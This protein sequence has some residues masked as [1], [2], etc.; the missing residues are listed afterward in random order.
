MNWT[1]AK[2]PICTPC[3]EHIESLNLLKDMKTLQE[4]M[5]F[6]D[7]C[8]RNL[9]IAGLLLKKSAK[10]GLS[11]YNIGTLLYRSGYSS[12]PS[13]VEKILENAYDLYKTINKSLSS[14]L[15]IEKYLSDCVKPV[16]RKRPRAL[17]S[18][19]TDFE[20]FLPSTF[21]LNSTECTESD[22]LFESVVT[23]SEVSEEE[24]FDDDYSNALDE[25]PTNQ[26]S[27]FSSSGLPILDDFC[28]DICEDE[29]FNTKLFY[30][31][32]AFMDITIQKKVK[33]LW[34]NFYLESEK[35]GGRIRSCSYALD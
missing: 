28:E 4:T 11:L 19:E 20:A 25:V 32:E 16:V 34:S 27:S 8:L 18:N 7:K 2:E 31:I 33:E 12:N 24:D 10:A 35:S 26:N 5:Q 17:S 3:L 6:P 23:I 15:K 21:S 22:S 14:R 29:A 9:R 30:Y 13:P 1:Q